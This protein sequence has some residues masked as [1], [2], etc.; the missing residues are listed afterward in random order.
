MQNKKSTM[1]VHMAKSSWYRND[2]GRNKRNVIG[3]INYRLFLYACTLHEC[4]LYIY[5]PIVLMSLKADT[6]K[7]NYE[8]YD[9]SS[10]KKSVRSLTH[11]PLGGYYNVNKNE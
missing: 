3:P 4:M 1:G 5:G 11:I 10:V 7:Y 8:V 6:K 9:F 2:N